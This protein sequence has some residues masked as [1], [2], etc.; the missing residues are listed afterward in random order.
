MA[1]QGTVYLYEQQATG[2]SRSVD[3]TY[4]ADLP[5]EDANYDKR[6]TTETIWTN[7]TENVVSAS[8]NDAYTIVKAVAVHMD[9]YDGGNEHYAHINYR[10][11]ENETARNNDFSNPLYDGETGYTEFV[12]PSTSSFDKNIVQWAYETLKN[13]P[14][15]SGSVD[16]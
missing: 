10:V 7:E 15:F 16:S 4:P 13:Q 9:G 11:Y 8:F 5:A 6:E 14:E 12:N 2:V 1:L 3:I